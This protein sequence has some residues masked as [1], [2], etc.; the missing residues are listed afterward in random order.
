MQ[1]KT[2]LFDVR[3]N[4]AHITL[5]RPEAANAINLEL[6]KDLM[7]ALMQCDEDPLIRAVLIKGSGPLFCAGGDVKSFVKKGEDLPHY[8]K[9]I[10]VHLHS[11]MSYLV[12]MDPPVVAAV[13]GSAA[14]AGMS[15]ACACDMT[16]AAESAKFTMAY[17]GIGL[18]PDGG[19]TYTLPRLVG[20]K[21]TLELALTNRLLSAE[22][23]R[24][25]GIVT[26]VLPE[27]DLIKEATALAGRLAAGPT[28]ALG[29]TKRL[30][31]SGLTESFEGQMKNESHSISEMARTA[32]AREGISAFVEKRTPTF[33]G[34]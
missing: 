10:T 32:D 4:V 29:A 27:K 14:G 25:W 22:E 2:L 23:A 1:F 5:N 31:Q 17:T 30:L 3:E 21:R 9:E 15:L 11:A 19:A 33:K 34:Q 26:R 8:L 6:A 28:K 24:N 20:I 7:Y 12:R 18:T 13:H 16:L